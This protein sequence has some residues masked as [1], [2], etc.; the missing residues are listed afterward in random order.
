MKTKLK[1]TIWGPTSDSGDKIRDC[2]MPEL[3]IGDWIYFDDIGAYSVSVNTKF[4]GF[5][6]PI[7]YYYIK[8]SKR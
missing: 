3:E 4:N 8:E 2:E 5:E 7:P 1:T 6:L